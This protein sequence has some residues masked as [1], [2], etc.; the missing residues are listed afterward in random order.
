MGHEQKALLLHNET[1]LLWREYWSNKTKH[2]T[3]EIIVKVRTMVGDKHNSSYSEFELFG[4]YSS[5]SSSR[6]IGNVRSYYCSLRAIM[7]TSR[8]RKNPRRKFLRCPKY[9][10]IKERCDYFLWVN[11][12]SYQNLKFWVKVLIVVFFLLSWVV[13]GLIITIM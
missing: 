1:K 6:L 2:N 13:F 9:K 12:E 5:L 3:F 11:Y 7:L 4:G 8:T 10:L